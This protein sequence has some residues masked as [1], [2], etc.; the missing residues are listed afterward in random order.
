MS[1]AGNELLDRPVYGMSQ[2]ARLLG[3]RTDGIRRWIDGYERQG[4]VYAPVIRERPTGSDTVTWGEFI[5]AGYLREYR[6]THVSLQYLRPVI[7][8]LRE[9]L[10]VQYP[11]ATLK[12]YTTGR[13]LAL[14]A[15]Q[16]VGLAPD[17]SIVILGRDGSLTP[18][19]PALAFLDKVE[20]NDVS[21][22][23]ERLFPLG[24]EAPV[25]LDPH[26][27][28]GEPTIPEIG[29]RTE[30]VAELVAAGE[31]PER[32]AEIYSITTAALQRVVEFERHHGDTGR[33]A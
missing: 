18:S 8:F 24:R 6:A 3:L 9:R 30:V 4:K 2:A 16:F 23:A 26:R 10:D 13:E 15:Q 5:E 19:S 32:V 29:V 28:F 21:D 1:A 22:V 25:V 7:G 31:E 12:P 33:A 17:L 27:G 14:A 20:F 11:L